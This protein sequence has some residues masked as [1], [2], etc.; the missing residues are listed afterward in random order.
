M[1][2]QTNLR[3]TRRAV[4]DLPPAVVRLITIRQ[5]NDRFGNKG[6]LIERQ[7]NFIGYNVIDEVGTHRS[8]KSEI[9]DLN[10]RRPMR[11]DARPAVLRVALQVDRD[12]DLEFM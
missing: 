12:I 11:Q 6:L 9:V 4:G 7:H 8:G 5:M 2:W 10:R 3:P 1:L